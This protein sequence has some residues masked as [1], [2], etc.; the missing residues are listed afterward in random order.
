MCK[1]FRESWKHLRGKLQPWVQRYEQSIDNSIY[2]HHIC[3][4][5]VRDLNTECL[6]LS[7]AY[8][9]A[10]AHAVTA[11]MERVQVAWESL[12]AATSG[13]KRKL[14]ASHELQK[15]LSSVRRCP[16]SV[17]PCLNL[18]HIGS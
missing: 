2:L 10:N 9:G 7:S 8:P 13:R 17:M 16:V 3:L 11:N 4:L 12:Q 14:K 18:F 6:R 5:Q 15:F 1:H